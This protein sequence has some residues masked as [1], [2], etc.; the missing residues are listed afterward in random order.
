MRR[1]CFSFIRYIYIYVDSLISSRLIIF[2]FQFSMLYYILYNDFYT[3]DSDIFYLTLL[4]ERER[5]RERKKKRERRKKEKYISF[6]I[7]FCAFLSFPLPFIFPY[8]GYS[9]SL[10]C[11]IYF[12]Y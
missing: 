8:S 12:P 11:F 4:G 1:L 5:E 3:D 7:I 6:P 10:I 2:L 9:S